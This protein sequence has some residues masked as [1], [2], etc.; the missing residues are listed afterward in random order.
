MMKKH[1]ALL[2]TFLLIFSILTGCNTVTSAGEEGV[3]LSAA[4]AKVAFITDIGDVHDHGFNEY[5]YLGVQEFS[6]ETGTLCKYFQPASQQEDDLLTC[7]EEAVAE[8]YDIIVMAGPLFGKPCLKAAKKNPGTLFLA[9]AVTPEDMGT[10]LIPSNIS[11]LIH[12]EEEAGFLAGYAAVADGYRELGFL[13]GMDVAPVV[14]FGHGYIQ[15]AN[16]AAQELGIRDVHMKYWYSDTFIPS[17][18]IT[19]KMTG[20]FQEGTEVIFSCGG[21]IYESALEAAEEEDGLLIGVDV[22]QSYISPRFITSATKSLSHTV[23]MAL[24]A[25]AGNHLVWPD[26]YA[27]TCQSFGAAEECIGLPMETSHFRNFSQEMYDIL[28]RAMLRDSFPI[29][30]SS[31][32]AHHPNTEYIT[33]DWQN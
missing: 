29:D 22:D 9:L 26:A 33:V 8:E 10:S 5:S 24:H 32:P 12:K 21:A 20:W 30:G 23:N 16:R 11:L 18:E 14:R 28:Y 15:G 4:D 25:A 7:I 2:L 1:W 6:E 19:E 31:N 13:G 27:G 17:E 3:S